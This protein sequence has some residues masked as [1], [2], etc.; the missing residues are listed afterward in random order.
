[1]MPS[2]NSGHTS[3]NRLGFSS[4][5]LPSVLTAIT[6]GIA[7][8]TPPISG[9][10]CQADCISYPYTDILERFPRDYV[11]MY[12]AI[13]LTG[14]YVVLMACIHS[15]A[16][17]Q[18]KIYSQVGLSFAIMAAG[19]LIGDYFVQV[20]VIQP[21]LVQGEMDG[22]AMLS[23]YNPHGVFIALEEIG[24]ILM[25]VSF[26]AVVPVFKATNAAEK[27][28]RWVFLLNF[29]LNAGCLALVS[30][31]YGIQRE[32]IFEVITISVN[33]LTLIINGILLSILYK[34]ADSRDKAR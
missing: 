14:L 9:P 1:M 31:V 5:M 16:P 23:Q 24:Y 2:D 3:L 26:F 18:K 11:W 27:A 19:I 20:S 15:S 12:P 29:L 28:V 4:A 8:F 10:F 17:S 32:Y 34:R 30:F 22:I 25:S 33:W 6:F 21:S 13:F 7:I